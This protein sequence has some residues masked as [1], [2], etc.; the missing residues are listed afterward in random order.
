VAMRQQV[1]CS[2]DGD[3]VIRLAPVVGRYIVP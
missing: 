2:F 1:R 3:A